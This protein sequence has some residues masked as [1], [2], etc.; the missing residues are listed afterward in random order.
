MSPPDSG[1]PVAS[2]VKT[3]STPLW[4][5]VAAIAFLLA[6]VGSRAR[7]L[8][9]EWS[10][11]KQDL[12]VVRRTTVVGY[13]NIHPNPSFARN[14]RDWY[15]DE[16]DFTMLWARWDGEDHRWFRIGRGDVDRERISYPIGRDVIQAIDYPLTEQA[17]GT[18]WSRIPDEAPV[19]GFELNGNEIVYPLQVLTKVLIINDVVG[20][21]PYLVT[22]NPVSLIEGT[23][24]VYRPVVQGQRITMGTSG[25]LHDHKPLLYDRS[26]ESLWV[27]SEE[28][29]LEA[30]AG[31]SKGARLERIVE[32]TPV[33]WGTWKGDHPRSRL[34]IGADRSKSPPTF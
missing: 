33:T 15:H 30:I 23:V 27:E 5:I 2:D 21:E 1:L 4:L 22:L 8:W 9:A 3:S 17:G 24:Q 19:V 18:I 34:L 16:G 11:L 6:F 25:Y 26:T 32:R 13:P 10:E 20:D 28:G 14:P 12:A 31:R 29:E 7:V